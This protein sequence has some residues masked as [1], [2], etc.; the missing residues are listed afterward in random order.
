MDPMIRVWN[1]TTG[2]PQ[3]FSANGL[4]GCGVAFSPDGTRLAV[5][6]NYNDGQGDAGAGAVKVWLLSTGQELMSFATDVKELHSIAFSPDGALLVCG[7]KDGTIRLW[8]AATGKK[9]LVLHGHSAPVKKVVFSPDGQRLASAS[10]DSTA[11]LW[12]VETGAE[13]LSLDG[14]SGQVWD[15]AFDPSG[16]QLATASGDRTVKVWD[17]RPLTPEILEQREAVSLVRFLHARQLPRREV[18]ERIRKAK[19]I[20]EAVREQALALAQSQDQQDHRP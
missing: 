5:A 13:V 2:Q 3:S 19:N 20:T 6:G 17:A 11:K 9:H 14:H 1:L 7:C 10:E 18:L 4:I 8:Q 12:D 15:V 16:R